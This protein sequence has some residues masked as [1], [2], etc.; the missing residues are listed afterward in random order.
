MAKIKLGA[1]AQDVRGSMAGT[2]FARNRYGAYS[3][4]K[5][6]GVNPQT[7]RQQQQR[8]LF[9]QASVAWRGLAAA[10]QAA[11]Q[12]WAA[13]HPIVD[14]FGDSQILAG[15]AAYTRVNCNRLMAGL[16]KLD[17]PPADDSTVPA[18]AISA[19]AVASTGT[20]TV[21]TGTQTANTGFYGLFVSPGVSPGATPGLGSCRL[22]KALTAASTG[23]T[24]TAVVASYNPKLGFTAGQKIV[25]FVQRYNKLGVAMDS[26]RFD[27]V[28]T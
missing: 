17:T 22:A 28:A 20:I 25:I 11:W 4:Q 9:S 24:I 6:T 19:T 27:V 1:L 18:N 16:A 10:D 8:A 15:N 2:T 14:I 7:A 3:R 13:N 21:T 23:T 5:V 26:T 12:A